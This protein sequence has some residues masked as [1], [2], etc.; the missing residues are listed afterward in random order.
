[1]QRLVVF[2]DQANNV[3]CYAYNEEIEEWEQTGLGKKW[4]ISTSPDSKLT[5][6]FDSNGGVVVAYQDPAGRLAGV[7]SLAEEE[8]EPF[9]LA[10]ADP[11]AGTPLCLENIDGKM[12]LFYVGKDISICYLVHDP[13]TGEWQGETT[14]ISTTRQY[15][16][17]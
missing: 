9:S 10:E 13:E 2:I 12:H 4:N 14:L 8:W 6:S 11:V 7:M 16:C 17:L 1:M 5:A 3:Q 15:M